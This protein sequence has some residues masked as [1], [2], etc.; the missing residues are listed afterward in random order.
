MTACSETGPQSSADCASQIRLDGVVYTSQGTSSH[1]AERHVEA[2][3][4]ECDDT[5]RDARGSVFADSP[6][7]V[8]TWV[9]AGYPPKEVLG[10]QYGKSSFGVFVADTV[11][12]DEQERIYA[13]LSGD[14]H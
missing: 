14:K 5:G 7:R 8:R 9:F 3:E 13:D 2:D 4:A 11:A 10:V 1:E 6:S 12:P